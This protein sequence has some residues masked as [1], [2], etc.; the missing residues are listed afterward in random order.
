MPKLGDGLGKRL[1]FAYGLF[2][3]EGEMKLYR[4]PTGLAMQCLRS[5]E[6]CVA[7]PL[8]HLFAARITTIGEI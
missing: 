3:V 8:L 4:A 7:V 2:E 1:N 6:Y 5:L